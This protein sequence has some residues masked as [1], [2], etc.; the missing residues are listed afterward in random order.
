MQVCVNSEDTELLRNTLTHDYNQYRSTISKSKGTVNVADLVSHGMKIT[1]KISEINKS[2]L[3]RLKGHL[4]QVAFVKVKA[5]WSRKAVLPAAKK[6]QRNRISPNL[7]HSHYSTLH[8]ATSHPEIIHSQ[9]VTCTWLHLATI[10]SQTIIGTDTI[11]LLPDL[12]ELVQFFRLSL[13]RPKLKWKDTA[14]SAQLTVAAEVTSISSVPQDEWTGYTPRGKDDEIPCRRMRSGSYIK[15]MG[16]E[17][18]GD[19]DTSPKPSPKVAARRESYLKATQPSLTELTTLKKSRAESS[20][21]RSR[22]PTAYGITTT[23]A[24][25]SL[26]QISREMDIAVGTAPE[27]IGLILGCVPSEP[28]F[29][30]PSWDH[31]PLSLPSPLRAER[32]WKALRLPV[33]KE[34]HP[35]AQ[36]LTGVGQS[37]A[38]M[39]GGRLKHWQCTWQ[40]EE[41]AEWPGFTDGSSVSHPEAAL[42]RKQDQCPRL[43]GQVGPTGC[44]RYMDEPQYIIPAV[45][46]AQ[47]QAGLTLE[48]KEASLYGMVWPQRIVTHCRYPQLE[49]GKSAAALKAHE[50]P[51]P[52]GYRAG[53]WG[54]CSEVI[55]EKEENGEQISIEK[56]ARIED[57]EYP[58]PR[59]LPHIET[60]QLGEP[61]KAAAQIKDLML[62]FGNYAFVGQTRST[63]R[64]KNEPTSQEPGT[65][66]QCRNI[67]E[68]TLRFSPPP[69]PPLLESAMVSTEGEKPHIHM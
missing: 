12:P 43:R 16:D 13:G 45:Q 50:Y 68:Y 34:A 65:L 53:T 54:F 60:Q 67:Y 11:Y 64:E 4:S 48:P 42:S 38:P 63:Y 19:S 30:K 17:D 7:T 69:V 57:G 14:T 44:G 35:Q 22:L 55:P 29:E 58:A 39:Q 1:G 52:G 31:F 25:S 62:R 40:V 59:L 24:A 27:K 36:Q 47:A 51:E 9:K 2:K 8:H 33:K 61:K 56:K 10:V 46:P 3:K 26:C 21:N 18:S 28:G 5:V 23:S 15:A 32:L 20:R 6:M 49:L 37:L 66:L 41:A